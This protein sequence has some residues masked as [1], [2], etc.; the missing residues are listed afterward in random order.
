MSE[1]ELVIS[2]CLIVVFC[3]TSFLLWY[4][5][6]SASRAGRP[7]LV[8]EQRTPVP[9]GLLHLVGI[10]FI[11]LCSQ[12]GVKALWFGDLDFSLPLKSMSAVQQTQVISLMAV[13]SIFSCL[14][15][16]AFLRWVTGATFIDLGVDWRQTPSR[17]RMGLIAFVMLAAP[18]LAIHAVLTQIQPPD[19]PIFRM[20]ESDESGRSI[21][22]AF[23]AAVLVAPVWEELLFRAILQGWLEN[24]VYTSR[25]LRRPVHDP[26]QVHGFLLSGGSE[27]RRALVQDVGESESSVV[28]P[29]MIP[30]LL[31]SA[32]FAAMHIG[33]GPAP[34]A[35][36]FLAIGLGYLY[37]RTHSIL[38]CIAVHMALNGLTWLVLWLQLGDSP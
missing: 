27:G 22:I 33:Q 38:P 13:S 11:S 21:W 1:P 19:H 4:R 15:C 16:V 9:W 6:F 32:I 14:G 24:I 10:V 17:I 28:Q 37:Q 2:N 25:W 35:L 5:Y 34:V 30:I 18:V 36:F 7:W 31:S 8:F 29:A 12:S 23:V 26:G 3:L 20:L